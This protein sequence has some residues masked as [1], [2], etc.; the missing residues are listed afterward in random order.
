MPLVHLKTNRLEYKF[1][2]VGKYTVIKGDS[3][4]GKTTFYDL[5]ELLNVSASL[6]QNLTGLH[7]VRVPRDMKNFPFE[8]YH[9][10]IIV[11]DEDCMALH[12][13]DSL[14]K[15]K[16]SNN[17]FIILT[18][19]INLAF[20]PIGIDSVYKMKTS[21]KFHTLEPYYLRFHS[22]ISND[23]IITKDR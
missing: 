18:R 6:V 11:L 15:F 2:I 5:V 7:F 3:G 14:S 22:T 19:K 12:F 13:H 8:E 21:G 4:T 1:N 9:D 16:Y 17:Y 20:L 23:T 10:T